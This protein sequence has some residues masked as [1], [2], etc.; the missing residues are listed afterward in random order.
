[1]RALLVLCLA[2]H[3]GAADRYKVVAVERHALPPHEDDQR[4][5]RLEGPG[6]L[7]PG[8]LVQLTRA[9]GLENPGRLRVVHSA[10]NGAL[11]VIAQRG[12]T[13]PLVG[14]GTA[15]WAVHKVPVLPPPEPVA[16]VAPPVA[17]NPVEPHLPRTMRE[18][19]YFLPGDGAL[20]P[21]GQEKVASW[22]REWGAGQWVVE[23]PAGA[24]PLSK[25]MQARAQA[26]VAALKGAGVGAIA[27]KAAPPA[28]FQRADQVNVVCRE[29]EGGSPG[30][31]PSH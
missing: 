7:S 11:A 19:V 14:D 21:R 3:A 25:V 9:G 16:A 30:S 2:A 8:T 29:G 5:Y 22:G 26:V 1:M 24:G 13:Y 6:P 18:A 17:L 15:P 4:L 23:I 28:S 10:P 12:D 31:R 20:S 27:V